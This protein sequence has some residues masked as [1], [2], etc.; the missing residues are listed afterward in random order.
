M[1]DNS[2]RRPEANNNA[3]SDHVNSLLKEGIHGRIPSAKIAELRKK[4]NNDEM[5]DAIQT[6]FYEELQTNR[7][8]AMKFVK[9]I[10]KKTEH[11]SMPLHTILQK[12]EKYKKQNKMSDMQFAEFK[13]IFEKMYSG[14]ETKVE[15]LLPSTNLALLFGDIYSTDGLNVKESDYP[16]VQD[17]IKLYTMTRGTHT[18]VILQSMQYTS[19]DTVVATATFN[20][21]KHSMSHAVHPVVVSMFAPKMMGLE[22][23]FLYTNI[24]HVVKSKY[25]KERV[26]Q[27]HDLLL[28]DSM[29]R[30]SVDVVCSSSSTMQDLR[31]RATVQVNLWNCVLQ[32][33]S[34]KFYDVVHSDFI[35]AIDDCKIF[36]HD[37]PD[38]LY[39]GDEAIVLRRLLSAMSFNPIDVITQPVFGINVFGN[40]MNLPVINNS[41]MSR[42]FIV[43]RIPPL[44]TKEDDDNPI[45]LSQC[46]THADTFKENNKYVPKYQEILDVYGGVIIFYVQRRSI[47]GIDNAHRFINPTPQF[48]QIPIHILANERLNTYGIEIE[49]NIDIKDCTYVLKSGVYL[50]TITVDNSAPQKEKDELNNIIECSRSFVYD[51]SR[52]MRVY[53][54]KGLHAIGETASWGD[55]RPYETPI[56]RNLTTIYFYEKMV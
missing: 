22:T 39:T 51:S 40:P 41:I 55:G 49:P 4:L 37:A 38:L 5:I 34:G 21:Q 53:M 36:R 27:H 19:L 28:L 24:A 6:A 3:V 30:D 43:C 12:A 52:V 18:Q 45:S 54:Y 32:L 8:R 35:T 56:L 50:K 9:F 25:N 7:K 11:T 1:S 29:I 44:G 47:K 26:D 10:Q 16:I 14:K 17:I 23:H 2:S 15:K 46:L 13:R 20:P 42:P 48:T 33:R 31:M